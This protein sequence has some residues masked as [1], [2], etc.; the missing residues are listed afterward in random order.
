MDLVALDLTAEPQGN[1]WLVL[2]L[3]S[4]GWG[5]ETQSP[6]TLNQQCEVPAP[7]ATRLGHPGPRNEAGGHLCPDC[8][9][10]AG[11]RQASHEESRTSCLG[12]GSLLEW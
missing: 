4:S 12:H 11:G 6:R 3:L 9:R 2:S 8:P 5:M 1:Q 7:P 10:P